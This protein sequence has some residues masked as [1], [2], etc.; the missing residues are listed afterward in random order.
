MTSTYGDYSQPPQ[1]GLA[2]FRTL[3]EFSDT[4]VYGLGD[5]LE[6]AF[7][8]TVDRTSARFIDDI[9]DHYERTP[10]DDIRSSSQLGI[11]VRKHGGELVADLITILSFLSYVFPVNT[12][13]ILPLTIFQHSLQKFDTKH[14]DEKVTQR[15][16]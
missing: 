9:I 11:R 2:T 8:I 15:M 3:D 4:Y 7:K 1:D 6:D 13:L 12:V 14:R 10:V 5:F 16:S